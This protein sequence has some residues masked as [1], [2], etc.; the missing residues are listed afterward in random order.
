M[1]GMSNI[2]LFSIQVENLVLL[3]AIAMAKTERTSS[4]DENLV[5]CANPSLHIKIERTS[6]EGTFEREKKF[7]WLSQPNLNP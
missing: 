2:H 4:N 1:I 6:R 5:R 7:N 3:R